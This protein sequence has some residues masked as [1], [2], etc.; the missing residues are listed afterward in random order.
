MVIAAIVVFAVAAAMGA[1]LASLL[2]RRRRVALGVGLTHGLV[3]LSAMVL[4]CLRVFGGPKVILYNDALLLFALVLVAGLF[5][6]A[7]RLGRQSPPLLVVWVHGMTA[8]AALS[9]L[10]MGYLRT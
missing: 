7:I 5:M 4:L 1:V 8:V 3:G 9:L 6:L 10:L 2:S